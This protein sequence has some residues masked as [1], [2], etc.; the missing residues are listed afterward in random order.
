MRRSRG[1]SGLL[2]VCGL[3][4][5]LA[6]ACGSVGT[7]G[8]DADAL[9][10][11]AAAPDA[12]PDAGGGPDTAAGPDASGGPD[13]L[14]D[15]VELH[16][17]TGATPGVSSARLEPSHGGWAQADCVGCHGAPHGG[18]ASPQCAGCHGPN[19]APPRP[20]GHAGDRCG[21]CHGGAHR[22]LGF[23]PPADCR[24]CHPYAPRPDDGCARVDEA[25]VVVVGAGGG[26]LAAAA[27]LALAGRH[28][29]LLEQH[30]KVGG[31]MTAFERGD[32]R[33]EV[34][35][36]AMGG[37]DRPDEGT[38]ALFRRLGI[39]DA[40]VP[41][42]TDPMYRAVVGDLELD[43]PADADAYRDRLKALFP[44]EA[45]GLDRLFQL[46]RDVEEAMGALVAWQQGDRSALNALAAEKPETVAR[47]LGYL[48]ATL[49]EI[50]ADHVTD[51]ALLAVLTQLACYAGAPPSR[52]SGALFAAMW[53]SYHFHGFWNFVGGSQSISDALAD[54]V[55][56]H[57]GEVRLQTRA[58]AIVVEDGRATEVRTATGECVRA[59][60]VVS[61]ASAPGTLALVGRE[62]LPADWVA[63]VDAA[64]AAF[65]VYVVYLGV[66]ADYTDAFGGTHEIILQ[67]QADMEAPLTAAGEC[68]PERSIL[69]ITN[70][71]VVDPL[72]A[73]PGHN[74]I[75]LTGGLDFACD[76]EWRWPD[77]AAYDAY[78]AEVARVAI[79][80]TERFLPG[81]SRSIEVVEVGTPRTIQE[82]TLNPRGTIYGSE[83]IPSNSLL[84]RL[85]QE[86]PIPNLFLAGAWT[87][88]GP[89]QS[90]VLQSG[91]LAAQKILAIEDGER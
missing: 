71:S 3:G 44:H 18:L 74:V 5:A 7:T 28:V 80:R 8:A 73:P 86:T 20:D 82:F 70:Y 63:R 50:L 45:D 11:G 15:A 58:T 90:A 61:N 75:T 56:A 39:A 47:I 14:P 67:D 46:F 72:V 17:V 57:G 27:T 31:S 34:S 12:R 30:N 37:L 10:D 55:R 60:W 38:S 29:V 53:T 69:L 85:P 68:A 66:A 9:P 25:D 32:Y 54:V 51:P 48:D 43:V 76:Q 1:A 65:S 78:A 19:G 36:H 64:P 22:T 88:P 84:G 26:G 21:T 42:R 49:A 35:L 23:L 81:L 79:E 62:A 52:L 13:A 83:P 2:F 40:V 4:L 59:R 16:A 87:F 89:G 33:F 24:A 41:V 91:E 77:R 6:A